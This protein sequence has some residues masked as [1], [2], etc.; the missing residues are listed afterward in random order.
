MTVARSLR[1]SVLSVLLL[2]AT[3][4]ARS[5]SPPP[6]TKEAQEVRALAEAIDRLIAEKWA[7]AKVRPA[8]GADDAEFFRRVWLDLAG[9]IPSAAEAR[10]FLDDPD[11]DK[12]AKAVERL[13]QGPSYVNHLSKVWRALLIPEADAGNQAQL[14]APDFEAWL[15]Q[16]IADNA[17]YDVLAREIVAFAPERSPN[18]GFRPFGRGSEAPT[19]Q[20]YY[21]A[22]ESKPENLAAGTA[23]TFLGIRIEC[24]QCHDHPFARWTREQFWGYAAFFGGIE[25]DGE[26]GQGRPARKAAGPPELTIPDSKKVVRAGFLDGGEPRWSSG[27]G[28][29]ALLADWMTAPENPFFA[30]AGA[31][32][33]WAHFFGVGLV[34]PIDDLGESNPSSHPELL[35]EL[36][37]QFAQHRYDFKFLIRAL[38]SSRAYELTSDAQGAGEVDPRLFARMAVKGL[39][40]EQLYDSILQA[41]GRP[42]GEND[43]G[44]NEFLRRFA[45]RDEKP[46]DTQTTI[47]QALSMMNGRL[48]SDSTSLARGAT[49]GAVVDAPFLD[50][51]EKVEALFLAT[52]SRKPRPEELARLVEYVERRAP[53]PSPRS[54][55]ESLASRATAAY[56]RQPPPAPATARNEAL[57]DVFWA[58]LNNAEFLFNH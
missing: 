31:N 30:R 4:A 39:T 56:R 24:A 37:R 22:K 47:L 7:E 42:R 41:T 11:P 43:P 28:P 45:R 57:A 29:R 8:P 18:G 6:P 38:T 5:D 20:A 19:P 51:A 16:K 54:L 10:D 46:T 13:L 27:V 17:G 50:T 34:D 40:G 26:A 49:L 1:R 55:V 36:A 15:R 44:R 35:D 3:T 33:L 48:I 52:L 23:R 14:A 25:A 32:R 9:K 12:R 2:S 53:E 58:L 21:L